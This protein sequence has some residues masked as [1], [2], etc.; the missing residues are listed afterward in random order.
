MLSDKLLLK[1]AP[2]FFIQF[3]PKKSPMLCVQFS[4]E[5][6]P[7]PMLSINFLPQKAP[8]LYVKFY[9]KK[10]KAPMFRVKFL[11]KKAPIL[12]VKSLPKKGTH[13]VFCV[14]AFMGKAGSPKQ[15]LLASHS[16]PPHTTSCIR[17]CHHPG[18]ISIVV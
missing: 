17:S 5:N 15:Y 6:P 7:P 4:L 2:T 12:C 13:K 3:L 8:M 9:Q 1:M 14:V 16:P 11:P 10:K 18:S